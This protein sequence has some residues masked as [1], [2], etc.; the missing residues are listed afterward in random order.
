MPQL[1]LKLFGKF[2]LRSALGAALPVPARKTRAVL[3]YLALSPSRSA[4]RDRLA[5]LLW[6]DSSESHARQS[7]RQSLA[8]LRRILP[9]DAGLAIHARGD[10]LVLADDVMGDDVSEFL[11][12]LRAPT[13]ESLRDAAALYTGD[14]LEGF[15]ARAA[16]FDDWLMQERSRLREIALDAMSRLLDRY[17][18]AGQREPAIRLGIQLTGFDPLRER[19]HRDLMRL[20]ASQGHHGAAL[21]QYRICREILRRELGVDPEPATDALYQEVMRKRQGVSDGTEPAPSFGEPPVGGSADPHAT[22]QPAAITP[23][24]RQCTSLAAVASAGLSDDPES[25]QALAQTMAAAVQEAA[26]R[27]GGEVVQQM[28]RNIIVVFGLPRAHTND[29]ERAVATAVA[30]QRALDANGGAKI[31]IASGPL[32]VKTDDTTMDDTIDADVYGDATMQAL[33]LAGRANPG[34]TLLTNT[35]RQSVSDL[36]E[37]EPLETGAQGAPPAHPATAIWRLGHLH[38][39][40]TTFAGSAFVGRLAERRLVAGALDACLETLTGQTMM[41]RGDAGIGKS[42]LLQECLALAGVRGFVCHTARVLDFGAAADRDPVAVL[43]RS[44]LEI[45]PG[46]GEQ[47]QSQAVE[48]AIETGQCAPE[49]RVFLSDLLGTEQTRDLANGDEGVDEPGDG[50][51]DIHARQRGRCAALCSLLTHAARVEPVVVAIED[52]H[53]AQADVADFLAQAAATVESHR[54]LVIVTARATSTILDTT[55]RGAIHGAP[56]TTLDLAPLRDAES[57]SLAQAIGAESGEFVDACVQRA[58]G[59]PLFLEQLVRTGGSAS[60]LVPDSVHSVVWTRLDELQPQDKRAAQ[61]ASVM[62]QHFDLADLR[63][64]LDD[65]AYQCDALISSRLIRPEPDGYLFNHALI[66]EGVYASLPRSRSSA[67]HIKAAQCFEGRD[68]LLYA[69]HLERAGDPRAARAYLTAVQSL[70]HNHR[71]ER[72]LTV[73]TRLLDKTF[74]AVVMNDELR[75]AF[76]HIAAGLN[77]T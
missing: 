30:V 4:T 40:D 37:V 45:D 29:P 28:G 55:L 14:L 35:V 56:L 13:L 34:D 58:G 1:D 16:E 65:P 47:E 23:E 64:L 60:L 6:A 44:V 31:A 41:F 77:G 51:M 26:R 7:L 52:V 48:R 75:E 62:G 20:Y 63:H 46:A 12:L 72:A 3:A 71:H 42:R 39:L 57:Q 54:L 76:E 70:M 49:Q 61:A 17:S 22:A 2:E 10:E 11:R 24:L 69:E 33:E 38:S 32:L 25:S 5:A 9:A 67:L 66:A 21:K 18:D 15:D 73:V 19:T 59:N 50:H 8:G 53:W 74:G 36:F 43:A 68:D 27:H